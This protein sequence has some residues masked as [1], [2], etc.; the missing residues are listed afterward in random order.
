MDILNQIIDLMNKEEV[1]HFKLFSARTQ[2]KGV[3]K[4]LEL[5]DYIRKNR[6][7]YE[8]GD[9]FSKLYEGE[10]KN[11]FY[12]LKNRLLGELNKSLMLQHLDD[13][14]IIFIFHLLSLARFFQHRNNYHV[15][16][17]Y[18]RKAE[19][20]AIHIENFEL[21]DFIYSELIKLSHEIPEINPEDYIMKRK[22]NREQLNHYREIDDILAAV[23]YRVKISHEHPG[24]R[25]ALADLL[26]KTI[27]DFS[28]NATVKNSAKLRFTLFQAVSGM[29]LSRRDYATLEEYLIPTYQEFKDDGLFTR[30]THETKI[31]M[32][33]YIVN[34]LSHR[35]KMQDAETYIAKL[36]EALEEHNRSH[37]KKFL[38]YFY[39]AQIVLYQKFNQEKCIEIL[40]MVV[41]EGT[42]EDQPLYDLLMR[43]NLSILYFDQ[44][45]YRKALKMLV[46]AGIHDAYA[47][48]GSTFRLRW[49]VYE[50]VLRLETDEFDLVE[51]R[52]DKVKKEFSDELAQEPFSTEARVLE[53]IRRM[54]D[55][56]NIRQDE[57]LVADIRA[58]LEETPPEAETEDLTFLD[59]N[60]WLSEKIGIP[61]PA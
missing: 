48:L 52:L 3:R 1:R 11:P 12:R 37:Y 7:E 55:A 39:N 28:Q 40:E 47:N 22:E 45:K 43:V 41:N 56:V 4:D 46:R 42:F 60:Y 6:D 31:K 35:G 10:S 32:L 18:I 59:Y 50:I 53:F 20:K 29:L 51:S 36:G 27:N 49:S 2:T 61:T 38:F 33:V 21:L 19:K 26:Q 23:I 30:R 58:F 57:E 9:I 8:E 54:N 44:K 5:F 13:D 25:G 16:F 15:A 24:E 14:D 34:T 17:H